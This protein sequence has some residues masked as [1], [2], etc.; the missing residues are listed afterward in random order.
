MGGLELRVGALGVELEGKLLERLELLHEEFLLVRA[1]ELGA[2]LVERAIE[3]GQEDLGL[4]QNEPATASVGAAR[5][6]VA[7]PDVLYSARNKLVDWDLSDPHM[8]RTLT[9]SFMVNKG[10]STGLT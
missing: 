6:R 9:G 8:P 4:V 1:H 5:R 7:A 3:R 2:L 10:L